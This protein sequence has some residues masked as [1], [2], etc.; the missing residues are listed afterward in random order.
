MIKFVFYGYFLIVKFYLS[1]Q[2]WF[3]NRRAKWRKREKSGVPEPITTGPHRP[4]GS[5]SIL[6]S[7]PTTTTNA[8]SASH[9][10]SGVFAH[11]LHVLGGFPR[12]R[13]PSHYE[14]APDSGPYLTAP[15]MPSQLGTI[16]P[17]AMPLLRVAHPMFMTSPM[18]SNSV[19]QSLPYW[20]PVLNL[21]PPASS[22]TISDNLPVSN[23][24]KLTKK[25]DI[26]PGSQKAVSIASLRMKAKKFT[27]ECCSGK[28]PISV[29]VSTQNSNYRL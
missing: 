27:E 8:I 26:S 17:S 6:Q 22:K 24:E 14:F 16:C 29:A 1:L 2:V 13:M 20:Y 15:S 19:Y 12:A 4:L 9:S 21:K 11:P 5:P 28:E 23:Q 10:K 7:L 18:S 3:Q 25:D